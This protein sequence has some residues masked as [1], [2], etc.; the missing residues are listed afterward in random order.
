LIPVVLEVPMSIMLRCQ[1]R[2]W[3]LSEGEQRLLTVKIWLTSNENTI[4]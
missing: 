1:D 2:R 4:L 3:R